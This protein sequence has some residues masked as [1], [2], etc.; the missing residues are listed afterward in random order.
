MGIAAVYGAVAGYST[1][2]ANDK[3]GFQIDMLLDRK[4]NT[5]NLFIIKYFNTAFLIDNPYAKKLQECKEMFRQQTGTRKQLFTTLVSFNGIVQNEY[6]ME[7]VDAA[8][9]FSELF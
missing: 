7:A 8:I 9:D 5:I 3:T 6:A 1:K 2:S 4:D